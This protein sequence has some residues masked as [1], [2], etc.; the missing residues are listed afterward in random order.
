MGELGVSGR[1]LAADVTSASAAYRAADEGLLAPP[2]GTIDYVPAVK[3]MCAAHEVGLVIPLT[4]LDLRS[5]ARHREEFAALGSE[6]MIG[7][8]KTVKL[9]RDKIL[10]ND[11]LG[12]VGL[13]TIRTFTLEQFRPEPFFP[14][15]IKPLRGSASVGTA[16]LHSE[17]ELRAH[18][19]TFG[20]LMLVQD[21]VPG[22]E[23][24]LDIYR[25]RGGEVKCVVPRQRLAIRSGEVE[26]GLTVQDQELISCGVRLG[27]GLDGIWGVVNAQCRRP[28]GRE[29]HFFE[30]NPRFGGGAP[31]SVAAGANLPRYVLEERLGLDV[32]ARLGEF[33]P[34]LLMLRYDEGVFVQAEDPTQLPGFDTPEKR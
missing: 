10:T 1:L 17:A 26:K 11:F 13:R 25:T 29:P 27:R 32:S 16:V 34:N 15:F 18:L 24:T 3:E 22:S 28:P 7:P 9:C 31:L 5:L 19:A 2:V 23:Y 14:C 8:P 4:D 6:V 20:D 30:I 12:G 21:Y 33:T